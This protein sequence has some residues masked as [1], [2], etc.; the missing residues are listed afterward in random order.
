MK[1]PHTSPP[2]GGARGRPQRYKGVGPSLWLS[3]ER[4]VWLGVCKVGQPNLPA[5]NSIWG[6]AMVEL[7][8]SEPE[9]ILMHKSAIHQ[10]WAVDLSKFPMSDH[11]MYHNQNVCM[12]GV[13]QD[14]GKTC[15]ANV[16]SNSIVQNVCPRTVHVISNCTNLL[17][18]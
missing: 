7:K 3:K 2:K 13:Y 11:C 14:F 4:G 6:H 9:I 17:I 18:Y 1:S 10:Q 15:I 16:F 5:E 8:G 12:E